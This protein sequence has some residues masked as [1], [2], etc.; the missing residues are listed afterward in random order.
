MHDVTELLNLHQTVDLDRSGLADSVDVVPCQVNEHD[1]LG[2]VLE[3]SEKTGSENLVLWMEQ[4][5]TGSARGKE[6]RTGKKQLTLG[7][8]A[9]V[10]GTSNGMVGDHI[11]L[12]LA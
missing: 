9:T 8:L 7:V 5:R 4:G 3:G 1:V 10:Y 2:S 11:P 6:K 12:D